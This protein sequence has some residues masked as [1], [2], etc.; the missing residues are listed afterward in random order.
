[1][2]VV[3]RLH[4]D[5]ILDYSILGTL[6]LSKTIY[7]NE[8]IIGQEKVALGKNPWPALTGYIFSTITTSTGIQ[9]PW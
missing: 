3:A 1:M 7:H 5:Y 4:I 6:G 2:P 8:W 9:I